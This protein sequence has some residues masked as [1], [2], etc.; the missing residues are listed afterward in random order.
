MKRVLISLF[1]CFISVNAFAM[2]AEQVLRKAE[3]KDVNG[4]LD[5]YAYEVE[6]EHKPC[7]IIE[8]AKD[9]VTTLK[10]TVDGTNTRMEAKTFSS[11]MDGYL[12]YALITTLETTYVSNKYVSSEG[13]IVFNDYKVV[14]DTRS[15]ATYD[16]NASKDYI[17]DSMNIS[18]DPK[19]SKNTK[20]YVIDTSVKDAK[21]FREEFDKKSDDEKTAE[22][23]GL[24]I[25]SHFDTKFFIDKKSLL[26]NSAQI[27]FAEESIYEGVSKSDEYK[28]LSEEERRKIAKEKATEAGSF[29][30][31][32][33]SDY[34]KVDGGDLYY[35]GEMI[36]KSPMFQ[37]YNPE[38]I[39]YMIKTKS[40]KIFKKG[41]IDSS[42]FTPSNIKKG[43]GKVP[44]EFTQSANI[45]SGLMEQM[46]KEMIK[47]IKESVK[48]GIKEAG[49]EAVKES[50]KSV[51]K[52]IFKGLGGF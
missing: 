19:Q 34:K 46:K 47:S 29:A 40:F 31:I 6:Y 4:S 5:L 43:K 37:E 48:E 33:Y 36:M 30:E 32:V 21:K 52:S 3:G 17:Y 13:T 42:L 26:L 16:K 8:E 9:M 45:Y 38:G 35:P 23:F 41:E 24:Y 20:E 22:E 1:L 7:L 18:F 11:K 39:Y 44:K 49:K 25:L 10:E 2:N 14:N 15:V 12:Y 51:T 27:R 28:D 50:A